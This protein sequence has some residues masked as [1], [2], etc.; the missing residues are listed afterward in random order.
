M[1]RAIEA[2]DG[3]VMKPQREG[4][5]HNFFGQELADA[6]KSL[7]REQRAA[8]TLM[9]RIFPRAQ[10]SVLVRRGRP[11]A[12]PALSELGLYSTFVRAPSGPRVALISPPATSCAPS[13]TASTRA[14]SPRV[15]RAL[16]A[17]WRRSG[18]YFCH[19][20]ANSDLAGERSRDQ[21]L[22]LAL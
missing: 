20:S 9:Q 16:R 12:G 5:G 21:L 4:G 7:A 1:R 19:I 10:E 8:F 2:P 17:R 14:A 18:N 22:E 3:Y 6:L 13:S 11:T 15:R